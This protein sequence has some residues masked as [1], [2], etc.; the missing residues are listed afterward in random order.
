MWLFRIT[1]LKSSLKGEI[2]WRG[3]GQSSGSQPGTEQGPVGFQSIDMDF[4][5]AISVFISGK[6]SRA[7]VDGFVLIAPL[8]Q[9]VIEVVLVGF[10][11]R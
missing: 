7:M 2:N 10:P 4:M 11:M 3:G 5:K 6:H 1:K 8:R 9:A